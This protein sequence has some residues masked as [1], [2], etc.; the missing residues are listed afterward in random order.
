M[1]TVNCRVECTLYTAALTFTRVFCIHTPPLPF[2]FSSV[3]DRGQ[4]WS[5]VHQYIYMSSIHQFIDR[6]QRW[7][8]IHQFIYGG[9]DGLVYTCVQT[10]VEMVQYTP[11]YIQGQRWSS[12]HQYI[13]MYSIHQFID[14]GQRWFS[15]HQFIYRGRDG[16][17]YTS[18]FTGVMVNYYTPVYKQG[19][20]GLVYTSIYTG[21]EVVQYTLV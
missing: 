9:R 2:S 8:S 11:V 6:G 3:I 20:G 17:V 16:L 18:I 4:R 21:V 15:T 14:R 10:G 5:S 7:S 12:V 13:Y 19:R 1:E